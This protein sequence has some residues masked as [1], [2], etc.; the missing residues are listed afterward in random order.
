MMVWVGSCMGYNY[1]VMGLLARW[2]PSQPD[3]SFFSFFPLD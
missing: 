3:R 2:N 1:M